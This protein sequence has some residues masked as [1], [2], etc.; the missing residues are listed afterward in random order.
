MPETIQRTPFSRVFTIEDGSGP[1]NVPEYQGLGRALG[2]DWP[3]GD[4]TPVRIPSES[5][6]GKFD[7]VDEIRGAQGLPSLPIQFRLRDTISDIFDLVTQKGC[8]IDIQV[9]VGKCQ[10]PTDFDGGWEKILVLEHSFGT[11]YSTDEWGALDADQDSAI[12]EE[13]PFTG[14]TAYQIKRLLAT[15]L[16]TTELTD[17]VIAI[18]ICDAATCGACGIPSNGCEKVF[19]V[20]SATT[21]SPGLPSEVLYSEDGGDTWGTTNITTLGLAEVPSDAA[22]VG[23]NLVVVSNDSDSLHHAPLKDILDGTETWTEMSTGFVGAGSPNAIHSESR[24]K[25][26]IVG[27]GGYVYFSSDI[28]TAVEVQSAGTVTTENLNDIHGI[29]R[30]N[31]VAVGASNATIY[32]TNGG[33]TWASVTGPAVGIALTAVWMRSDLEW[34]VGTAGGELYYTRDQGISWTAKAFSG[35]GSGQVEDIQF[36]K[37]GVGYMSH[38]LAAAGRLFRTI[39]GG[40]SWELLPDNSTTLP[41]NDAINSIAACADSANVV[42][43][44]GLGADAVDG[45]IIK[46]A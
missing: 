31:L 7:T 18:V 4:V 39:N 36:S 22:C 17:E 2:F 29:D 32:T 40:Q 34:L 46:L 11:N 33:E 25:T 3:Q 19:A 44:G 27:D 21:G 30:N 6:Y 14:R 45:I 42:F 35:S 20:T 13:V 24:T 15:E 26:W 28:E 37:E 43:A 23:T 1:A 10:E 41:T 5:V 12:N 16:A 9:H 38:T 8:P